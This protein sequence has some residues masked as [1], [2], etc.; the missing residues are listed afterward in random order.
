ME[1]KEGRQ[2]G[3]LRKTEEYKNNKIRRNIG[4]AMAK[5]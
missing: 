3:R 2:S 1:T 4:L 5:K